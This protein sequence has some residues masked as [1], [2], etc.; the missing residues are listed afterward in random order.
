VDP[1][2]D[3]KDY[4]HRGGRTARAGESGKVVTLV[5]PDQ[6][7]DANRVMSD[8]GVRPTVTHVRSGEQKLTALTGAKR[9][10]AGGRTGGGDAPFRGLGTRPGRPGR[11]A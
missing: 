10:P 6:R 9:P 5:T 7:R 3:A 11:P 1:P 2:A 4:L 8:A